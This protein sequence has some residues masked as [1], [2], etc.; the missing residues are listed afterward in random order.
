[1]QFEGGYR[2][3]SG[4]ICCVLCV[5]AVGTGILFWCWKG[6]SAWKG[7]SLLLT[8]LGTVLLAS[9]FTPNGGPPPPHGLTAKIN[10]FL[11]SQR[12]VPVMFNQPLFYVAVLLLIAGIL[13][14]YAEG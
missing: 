14:G 7:T 2:Y 11:K 13:M 8:L 9:A 6:L 3:P 1:M 12:A 10:W 5:F 4:L